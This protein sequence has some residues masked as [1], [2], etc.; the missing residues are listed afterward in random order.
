MKNS[1]DRVKLTTM[2]N[3]ELRD[4]LKILAMKR[5]CN[6]SDVLEQAIKNYLSNKA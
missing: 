5:R 3:P 1:K 4:E 6:F 2:I